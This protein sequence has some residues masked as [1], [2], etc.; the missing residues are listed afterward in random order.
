MDSDAWRP[1]DPVDDDQGGACARWRRWMRVL[2]SVF[3]VSVKR[4]VVPGRGAATTG[5]VSSSRRRARTG[6]DGEATI[7]TA[8]SIPAT[9]ITFGWSAMTFLRIVITLKIDAGA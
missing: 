9:A 2:I 8:I 7:P 3:L 6:G 1:F 5:R 4:Q